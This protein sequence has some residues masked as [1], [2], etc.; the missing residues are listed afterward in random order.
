MT[1]DEKYYRKDWMGDVQW[2]LSKL[3][4]EFCG[5]FHH[6]FELKRCGNGIMFNTP[7]NRLATYDYDGLTHLVALGHH[8]CVRVGVQN[9][10]RE[11][12]IDEDFG[13]GTIEVTQ[14]VITMHKR[15]EVGDVTRMH[16]H[17]PTLRESLKRLG[18]E[19]LLS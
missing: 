16:E 4:A 18:F 5:G 9:E 17:H 1:H 12:E 7:G 10:Q 15:V 8:H 14:S 11:I 3:A 13:G 19:V 2:D 6:C